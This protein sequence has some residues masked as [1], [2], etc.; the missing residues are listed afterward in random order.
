MAVACTSINATWELYADDHADGGV[1]IMPQYLYKCECGNRAAFTLSIETYSQLDKAGDLPP[2]CFEC[3]EAFMKR[4]YTPPAT[5]KPSF[6]PGFNHSFGRHF[7]THQQLLDHA[8]R[9]SAARTARTGI[10]H[11]FALHDGRDPDFAQSSGVT[12]EGLDST[13]AKRREMG[14]TERTSFG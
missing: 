4:V 6:E 7:D 8:S 3:G 14:L 11:N 9:E 1:G 10:K 13:R 5:P 2:M 12:D